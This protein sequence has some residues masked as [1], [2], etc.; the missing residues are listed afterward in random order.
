MIPKSY[1]KEELY[2]EPVVLERTFHN[3]DGQ[4]LTRGT[5]VELEG[6]DSSMD[7]IEVKARC[8]I[9]GSFVFMPHLT[10]NDLS[11]VRE[12]GADWEKDFQRVLENFQAL[13]E[14]VE[15]GNP[16]TVDDLDEMLRQIQAY[17]H[18]S[19]LLIEKLK[20][21][22]SLSMPKMRPLISC[23]VRVPYFG[24]Y[25]DK[26]FNQLSETGKIGADYSTMYR[27]RFAIRNSALAEDWV[28]H[29]TPK[30]LFTLADFLELTLDRLPGKESDCEGFVVTIDET[31]FCVKPMLS[32]E[33]VSLWIFQ[34]ESNKSLNFEISAEDAGKLIKGFRRI[35]DLALRYPKLAAI[36]HDEDDDCEDDEDE[37]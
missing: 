15:R 10:R 7:D 9:C 14:T 6:F 2:G 31:L 23:A 12:L 24:A 16:Q 36:S 35:G 3:G 11:V 20:T 18:Y 34:V 26:G 8:P 17:Y 19:R 28:L 21:F 37:N 5:V 30:T 22:R 13:R 25:S 32:K 27:L 1:R 33:T 4:V 29:V